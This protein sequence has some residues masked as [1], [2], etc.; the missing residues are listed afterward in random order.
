MRGIIE[1]LQGR[2]ELERLAEWSIAVRVADTAQT[3]SCFLLNAADSNVSKATSNGESAVPL[4]CVGVFAASGYPP[5]FAAA[6]RP[7]LAAHCF[8]CHGPNSDSRRAQ[9][10]LDQ[11]TPDDGIG[12]ANV[13]DPAEPSQSRLLQRVLSTDPEIHAAT[14]A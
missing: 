3:R 14:R 8:E 7:L 2:A 6:V 12:P 10:R 9:L 4:R 5:D 13:V 1:G 11:A